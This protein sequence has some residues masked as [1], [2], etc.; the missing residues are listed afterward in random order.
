MIP[1]VLH[2]GYFGNWQPTALN[3]Q[4]FESWARVLP[5]YRQVKWEAP[6]IL[7]PWFQRAVL[8]SA[9]NAHNYFLLYSLW[10][11][12]GYSMDNDVE[13][14]RPFEHDHG[15]VVG[16]QKDHEMKDSINN[17]VIGATARHP[18][19]GR[20]LR[21]MELLPVTCDP[22]VAGPGLLTQAM[23]ELGFTQPGVERKI[24]DVQ[25]Y[26]KERFSPF[27]H[28]QAKDRNRATERTFAIHW[29]QSSWTPKK[30]AGV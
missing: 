4:C 29:Y 1:R 2:F 16:F 25:V 11:L 8:E 10:K 22:L 24:G 6:M 26:G 12:G 18:V 30:A 3:H 27:F 7:S 28:D 21:R 23:M 17:C 13:A 5:D 15:L 9:I 20:I 19:I 14:L